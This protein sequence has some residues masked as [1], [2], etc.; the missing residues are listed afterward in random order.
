MLEFLEYFKIV[1]IFNV[2]QFVLFSYNVYSVDI[3]L[4]VTY[5]KRIKTKNKWLVNKYVVFIILGVI[6]MWRIRAIEVHLRSM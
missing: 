2:L 4:F 6:S 3:I 1:E 5:V